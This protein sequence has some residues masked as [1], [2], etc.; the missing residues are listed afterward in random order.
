MSANRSRD[1][2]P[3]LVMLESVEKILSYS[4]GFQV[5]ELFLWVDD[6][7]RFNASL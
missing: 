7:V 6:Q 2:L 5:A 1:L 4:D 3:L